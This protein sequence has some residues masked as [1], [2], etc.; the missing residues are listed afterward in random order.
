MN[1]II[2]FLKQRRSVMIRNLNP[3]AL[4]QNDLLSILECGTRVPD[5]G[6][7]TPWQIISITGKHRGELGATCLR[8][9]FARINPDATNEMLEFEENRFN[10]ASAV[11]CVISKPVTHSKIPEW[12]MHLSAGAV[13]QNL[14]TA[15]LALGY[16]AQWVTHWY[17]YNDKMLSTLGGNPDT[18]KIAGFIYIGSMTKKPNERKRP[19]L[20]DVYLSFEHKKHEGPH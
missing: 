11:L 13:C 14:L 20:S 2:S 8:S 5:H 6:M 10:R 9:E 7:L 18:D 16:G 12:E 17:S 3:S 1:P 4:P 19:N 15:A